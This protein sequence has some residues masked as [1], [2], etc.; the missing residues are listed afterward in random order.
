MLSVVKS[1][2]QDSKETIVI[3]TQ[4]GSVKRMRLKEFEKSTRAKRGVV[5][6]RELKS[7]PHRVIGFVMVDEQDMIFIQTEKG[8]IETLKAADIHYSDRYSNGS[9]IVDEV[10]NGKVS[11]I[12]KVE[13]P[14]KQKP[15]E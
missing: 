8:F 5:I 15:S 7:N 11:L 2:S 4:R 6:L 13:A 9:F 3:A 12:C 10:D 14:E 1:L